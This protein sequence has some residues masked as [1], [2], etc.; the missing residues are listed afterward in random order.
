M[1][2][3]YYET[4]DWYL[5]L[6][7]TMDCSISIFWWFYA[8]ST[9]KPTKRDGF[10]SEDQKRVQQLPDAERM[11]NQSDAHIN[12]K[13]HVR[14]K[15]HDV[16]VGLDLSFIEDLATAETDTRC[17]SATQWCQHAFL[18]NWAAAN[19]QDVEANLDPE[20]SKTSEVNC[21]DRLFSPNTRRGF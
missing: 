5:S 2:S 14:W 12:I 7:H 21:R 1:G 9:W 15:N 10:A 6:D 16:W 11:E 8:D 13:L 4:M 20:K 3:R 17:S 18:Q 19:P